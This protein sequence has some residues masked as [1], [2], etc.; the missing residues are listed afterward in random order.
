[1]KKNKVSEYRKGQEIKERNRK[2]KRPVIWQEK[3]IRL[4][5]TGRDKR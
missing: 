5:N 2:V 1:M 4:P 3:R